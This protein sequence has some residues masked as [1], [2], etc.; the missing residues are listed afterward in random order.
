MSNSDKIFDQ[1]KTAAQNSEKNEFEAMDKVWSRVEEKLDKKS[2]TRENSLLKKLTVL[3]SF[4]LVLIVLYLLFKPQKEPEKPI[5]N[6]VKSIDSSTSKQQNIEKTND[7]IYEEKNEVL[8]R[9]VKDENQKITPIDSISFKKSLI[10]K[11]QKANKKDTKNESTW[12]VK[13]NYDARGV[14]HQE[15]EVAASNSTKSESQVEKK[16]EPLLV[17]NNKVSKSDYKSLNEDE[18][19]SIVELKEPLYIINSVQYT[20]EEMFGK[21]PTSPYAPLSKQKIESISIV[22]GEKAV[23]M[24]GKKGINGV[25]IIYTKDG[26]PVPKKGK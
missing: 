1:I 12:L 9:K 14:I 18:I 5:N 11:E 3:V 25:V 6:I 4:F 21:N 17:I 10:D 20:E 19:E 16:E 24:F 2:L 26:K 15:Q 23:A 13:N 22:Q 8:A 7:S